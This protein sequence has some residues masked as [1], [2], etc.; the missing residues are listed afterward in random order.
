MSVVGHVG[1]HLVDYLCSG[2]RSLL[3]RHSLLIYMHMF[4]Y[5]GLYVN[6]VSDSSLVFTNR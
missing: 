1:V 3:N 4:Y 2:F 6:F 5:E